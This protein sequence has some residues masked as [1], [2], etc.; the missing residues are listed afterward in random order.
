MF[1]KFSKFSF[2]LILAALLGLSVFFV[3]CG[4]D[5]DDADDYVDDD[6]QWP[7]NTAPVVGWLAVG[8][9][10]SQ[11]WDALYEIREDDYVE[12]TPPGD[13][14][15]F[16]GSLATR[17]VGWALNYKTGINEL[18]QLDDGKWTL[19]DPQPPCPLPEH[20]NHYSMKDVKVFHD[21]R[22]YV[23]CQDGHL[24]AW[25]GQ[26]W[27]GH[28]LPNEEEY[29]SFSSGID[30]L[31]WDQCVVWSY[32]EIF[33]WD[34]VIFA[35]ENKYDTHQ[36]VMQNPQ[37]VY[38]ISNYVSDDLNEYSVEVLRDGVWMDEDTHFPD[39][40]DDR[41][42]MTRIDEHYTSFRYTHNSETVYV[43]LKDD[44]TEAPE[45]WPTPMWPVAFAEGAGGLGVSNDTIYRIFGTETEPIFTYGFYGA[46]S[47]ILAADAE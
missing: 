23:L 15:F 34:G 31:S 8:T 12:V 7:D 20:P 46:Q 30:C 43:L 6:Y 10:S 24:M 32:N 13:A 45:S 16:K 19:M 35:T 39:D 11:V 42:S 2:Y 47:L 40:I 26:D 37:V 5:D 44:G 41:A 28:E 18:Y 17:Y 25:D 38:R 21:E 33:W 9:H 14:S 29:Q 22:G 27:T 4:D 3:N 1:R 36:M